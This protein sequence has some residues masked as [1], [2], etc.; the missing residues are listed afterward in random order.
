MNGDKTIE[1]LKAEVE[2]NNLL[3]RQA[4][5]DRFFRVTRGDK[6][7]MISPELAAAF[8]ECS[9]RQVYRWIASDFWLPKLKDCDVINSF[10]D[11]VEELREAW[12]TFIKVWKREGFA[13]K[14]PLS[15]KR[16]FFEPSIL[17]SLEDV[18]LNDLERIE[19][20]TVKG[21]RSL[22]RQVEGEEEKS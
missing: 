11:I 8:L 14:L 17:R 20:L 15:L 9:Y 16:A 2:K 21:L 10:L 22:K 5:R 13:D 18:E 12:P 3:I 7:S 6:R 4:T 1:E 19:E